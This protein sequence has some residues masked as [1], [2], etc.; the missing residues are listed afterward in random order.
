[1]IFS[2]QDRRE[3]PVPALLSDVFFGNSL[4]TK[5]VAHTEGGLWLT[6]HTAVLMRNKYEFRWRGATQKH[7]IYALE[8]FQ[9][10][11]GG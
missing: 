6:A 11:L 2:L 1:M 8:G 7:S 9:R 5:H 4:E 3:C 10:D